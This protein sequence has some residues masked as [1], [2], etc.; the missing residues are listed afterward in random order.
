[1]VMSAFT[2]K[3]LASLSGTELATSVDWNPRSNRPVMRKVRLPSTTLPEYVADR[4]T[5][6]V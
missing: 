4:V 3:P 1:M 5:V 6:M 2:V